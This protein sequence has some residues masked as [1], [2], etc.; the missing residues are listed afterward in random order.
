M[1]RKVGVVFSYILMGLEILTSFLFTPY[2][3]RCLGQSQYGVYTLVNSISSYLI[4]LDLGIGNSIVRYVA[5]FRVTKQQDQQ[6]K[7]AG[8]TLIFYFVIA[9]ITVIVGFAF[10]NALPDIFGKGLT[11]NELDLASEM[12]IITMLNM[13]VTFIFTVF[14]K[15]ILAF[16]HYAISKSI[17]ILKVLLRALLMTLFLYWGFGAV[18]VVKIN[19]LVTSVTGIFSMTY[20]LKKIGIRPQFKKIE[21]TFIREILAYSLFIFL[22]MIATQINAMADHVL[23]GIFASSAILAIYG[24]G[25]QILQYYQQIAN[26]VNGVLMPG[27][28]RLVERGAS[29]KEIQNEMVR[30][31]RILFILLAGIFVTFVFAGQ[32]FVVMWAGTENKDAYY[33]IVLIMIP[34]VFYLTEA[35]G[36]Q[37]LW[38][39]NK[40]KLQAV[41]KLCITVLNVGL[42]IVLIKWNALIGATI[43]TMIAY[44]L[45]DVVVMN[46][47]F[48]K[49][50]GISIKEYYQ[51]LFSGIIKALLLCT[52]CGMVLRSLFSSTN[53]LVVFVK[54]ILLVLTYGLALWKWGMNDSE[55]NIV[56]NILK[57]VSG[58]INES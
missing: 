31:G 43:G 53:W 42:S 47:V 27:V 35:I 5:K 37:I 10:Q 36:T 41:I 28:V 3:I 20:V 54:C 52:L 23:L 33:V 18:A 29:A 32:D 25:S 48:A 51:G 44:L 58:K 19:L 49:D 15:I 8:V 24:I 17:S 16:E 22:Q 45:G 4:L 26:S 55:K 11:R 56:N 38:A 21:F 12:L 13:A 40:H 39:M 14:D 57:K 7:F 2:L 6:N 34:M 1:G 50:I 46:I 9:I 30:I